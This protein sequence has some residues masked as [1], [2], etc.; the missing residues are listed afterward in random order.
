MEYVIGIDVGKYYLD[1]SIG[2][3]L[4]QVTNDTKGH[5]ELFKRLKCC[6]AKGISLIICEASG[7]YEKVMVNLLVSKKYPVHVAHGNHVRAFAKARGYLAKTDKI[8][9]A[10]LQDYAK[11]LKPAADTI[12]HNEASIELGEHLK[13]REQLIGDK[14]RE[15]NRLDKGINKSTE[16]SIRKHIK[17]LD[18]EIK[19]VETVIDELQKQNAQLQKQHDLLTSIPGVGKLTA[20]YLLAFLPEIGH[21]EHKSLAALVGVAP[22]NHD[23]GQHKG[24]RFIQGGRAHLRRMLYMAALAATRWNKDL[25]L[26]YKRLRSAGKATKVALTAVMRKLLAVINSIITR[27]SPWQSIY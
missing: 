9:A 13:R 24:K 17:W 21:L 11:T 8:D 12:F 14:Q 3:E 1:I 7:G 10:I 4:L 22:F 6:E 5:K 18:G 20:S 23:S 26:F 25:S 19:D 2:S 16:R 27:Q 15:E